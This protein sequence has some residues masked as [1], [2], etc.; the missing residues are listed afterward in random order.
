MPENKHLRL[1]LTLLYLALGLLGL[2]LGLRFLLPWLLPFLI[3]LALA[4]L[5][6]KPVRFLIHRLALPRWAASALCSALLGLLLAGLLA[7]GAW[8]L[9]YELSLLMDQLPTLLSALPNLGDRWSAWVYR[10]VTAAPIPMQDDL[11]ALL[12]GLADQGASLPA[13]IY[14][15]ALRW[16]A[17]AAAAAPDAL[18][19]LF[20]TAIATYFTSSIRPALLAFLRRQ[21]PRP[22][23]SR[24]RQGLGRMKAT[25]GGW[26]R[27]QGTLMLVTFGELSV[28]FLVLGVDYFLLLAALVALVDA[29]PVFGT[30]TILLP[31]GAVSLL[32]G[33]WPMAAGLLILYGT[34]SAVRGLLEP[35]LV[36]D[37]VGLP[38]LAALVAMYVGFRV[39][40]V[41]GMILSPLF[42]M[43]A[44]EL[45]DC[46]FL[47]LWR[48]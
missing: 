29:L 10:F 45:H 33:D 4:A 17:A 31:W 14:E 37:R 1:L 38:P 13:L 32:G 28:G 19:L 8:R 6:E 42:A 18:L 47:R 11:T 2:W 44:K 35:K 7:L 36:G 21:V 46:G 20:T 9:W 27:A 24:V 26:L 3:A 22:W 15:Y 40:G 12:A 34:V 16:T 39:F 48:D 5:L 25:F 43:F 41:A 30:G 23:R